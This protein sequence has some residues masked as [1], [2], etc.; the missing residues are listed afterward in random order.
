MQ[1]TYPSRR[2]AHHACTAEQLGCCWKL[3]RA[4]AKH[5]RRSDSRSD[6]A[7]HGGLEGRRNAGV[8]GFEVR[9]PTS[10]RLARYKSQLG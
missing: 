9:W 2:G 10:I 4:S 8:V 7:P 6:S 5:S 1:R 3:E